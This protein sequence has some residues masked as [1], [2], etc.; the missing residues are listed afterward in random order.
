MK[1]SGGESLPANRNSKGLTRERSG[2]Q[3]HRPQAQQLCEGR[4][5]HNKAGGCMVECHVVVATESIRW[6][7][8]STFFQAR[9]WGHRVS[10]LS[11]GKREAAKSSESSTSLHPG[12]RC[13]TAC[14]SSYPEPGSTPLKRRL[15]SGSEEG[16]SEERQR[17]QMPLEE[18]GRN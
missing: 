8:G 14:T 18:V 9:H 6:A 3:W 13:L 16:L 1:N 2:E 17:R 12:L 4:S 11:G 10:R 7:L 15:S 5:Q